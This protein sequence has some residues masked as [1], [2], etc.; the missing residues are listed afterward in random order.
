M[1]AA[2]GGGGDGATVGGGLWLHGPLRPERGCEPDW[3][4]GGGGG[5][6]GG[7][8]TSKNCPNTIS[9]SLQNSFCG[10]FTW[11]D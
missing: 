10:S 4:G 6:M 1:S 9:I 5:L 8:L 7:G 11:R 3:G 2:G